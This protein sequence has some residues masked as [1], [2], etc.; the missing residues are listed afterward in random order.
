M[1]N[2]WFIQ[3]AN[4]PSTLAEAQA[5]QRQSQLTKPLGSLGRLEQLAITL[6]SHQGSQTPSLGQPKISVFAADHGIASQGVSAFPQAVTREMVKNF[7]GGGAAINALANH[8][9]CE[10]EV[11]N[12]GTVESLDE[13]PNVRN[14]II[15]P[16]TADFSTAPAMS[17]EQCLAAL[18][19]G[20][21]AIQRCKEDCRVFIGGEMGIGNTSSASALAAALLKKPLKETT[22]RGTGLDQDGLERKIELL[23]QSLD[24]ADHAAS[25]KSFGAP[26]DAALFYLQQLGGFEIAALT[27]AFIAAAQK[28]ITVL[29]DGFIC[30]AA[31]LVATKINPS[32]QTWLIASHQSQEHGH[33]LLLEALELDALLSIN[34]RLGEAS[35]AAVCLPLLSQACALHNHMATFVEAGVNQ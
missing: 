16:G 25:K 8:N 23:Q 28:G 1:T 31:A 2:D 21:Q 26:R 9:N 24:R 35:G 33:R 30:T 12:L 11:I 32:I 10:L 18:S 13:L 3:A 14:E 20:K 27:G 6:S 19:I 7:S 15:A 22:G 5:R 34:M 17:E 29:V 4:E